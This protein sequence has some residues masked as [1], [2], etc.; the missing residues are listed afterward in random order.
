MHN[1]RCKLS[2]LIQAD[3]VAPLNQSL[4]DFRNKMKIFLSQFTQLMHQ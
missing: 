3:Q 2:K 1:D 4:L